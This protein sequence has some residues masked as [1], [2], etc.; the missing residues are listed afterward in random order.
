MKKYVSLLETAANIRKILG[1]VSYRKVLQSPV[2]EPPHRPAIAH[3]YYYNSGEI[4]NDEDLDPRPYLLSESETDPSVRKLML[5]KPPYLAHRYPYFCVEED[6]MQVSQLSI[7]N[8]VFDVPH[9][10]ELEW[11]KKTN[12]YQ[13][14]ENERLWEYLE[15]SSYVLLFT[16]RMFLTLFDA[17]G[18]T[19]LDN[20]VTI[21][22]TVVA[23]TPLDFLTET[24]WWKVHEWD[25][26]ENPDIIWSE[27]KK[28]YQEH[29]TFHATYPVLYKN[30]V[31]SWVFAPASS[32]DIWA[33]IN[34]SIDENN[35][36]TQADRNPLAQ[37]N[38]W[39]AIFG[40]LEIEDTQCKN[41]S[42]TDYQSYKLAFPRYIT[43]QLRAVLRDIEPNS[44]F[45][46]G[47]F[48][49]TGY[50]FRQGGEDNIV[51]GVMRRWYDD[52]LKD[53]AKQNPVDLEVNDLTN[54]HDE[55]PNVRVVLNASK[56][57][58]TS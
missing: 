38:I 16:Y 9:I 52:K 50:Q 14:P 35:G 40:Q 3:P 51:M 44:N 57:S 58:W 28:Q 54:I 39:L 10:A 45:A 27:M 12:P 30:M 7:S 1:K 34:R 46:Y 42:W 4:M 18:I 47:Y 15:L 11:L 21:Q 17:T 36:A 5:R 25:T 37:A 49:H 29:F 23:N 31:N 43:A 22:D 19:E 53:Y 48:N 55:L 8:L 56:L 20:P 24:H 6:G 33:L 41:L 32:A 13:F 26:E 2:L